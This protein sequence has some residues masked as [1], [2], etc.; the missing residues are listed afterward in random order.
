M[1][2]LGLV[3]SCL[4]S[5]MFLALA[6]CGPSVRGGD[7]DDTGADA[8]ATPEPPDASV[9][10]DAPEVVPPPGDDAVWAH[11]SGQLYRIDPVSLQVTSV[12]PI[13]F[14][15]GFDQLTDLAMDRFGGM[16]GI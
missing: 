14:P 9:S 15:G 11:T 4:A 6:A 1:N 12:G 5:V 8:A 2:R 7:D 10:P 3:G 13:G 16:V